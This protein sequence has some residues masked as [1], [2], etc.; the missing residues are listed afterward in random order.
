MKPFKLIQGNN[1]NINKFEDEVA[2][3]IEDGYEFN[4]EMIVKTISH[5]N[6]PTE[7]LFFQPMTMEEHLDFEDDFEDHDEES[8]ESDA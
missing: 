8:E 6:K 3:A 5:A 2:K 1:T 4:G 7:V